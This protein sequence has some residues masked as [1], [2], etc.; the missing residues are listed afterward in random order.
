M[1]HLGV[2]RYDAWNA[3]S[4]GLGKN[5]LYIDKENA[6]A[7]MAKVISGESGWRVQ[8]SSL[9]LSIRLK[10]FKI[11]SFKKI[12]KLLIFP[13]HYIAPDWHTFMIFL[14]YCFFLLLSINSECLKFSVYVT[15]NCEERIIGR[16]KGLHDTVNGLEFVTSKLFFGA[17]FY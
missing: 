3:L 10:L 9:Q 15:E 13:C 7:N 5:N 14:Y 16:Y 6:K 1:K 2:K 12:D 4:N 11:K 17:A 8:K